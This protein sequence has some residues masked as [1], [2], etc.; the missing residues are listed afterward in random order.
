MIVYQASKIKNLRIGSLFFLI[1]AQ[2]II[3]MNYT[4]SIKIKD[5]VTVG[6]NATVLPGI[7]I[8]QG[9]YIGAGAVVT[10]NV[11][12]NNIVAGNPAKFLKKIKQN[13]DL[14]IFK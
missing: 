9:A 6:L 1:I 12:K 10:K 3:A 11:I 13:F 2:Q 5:F 7:V 8:E 4:R 14:N